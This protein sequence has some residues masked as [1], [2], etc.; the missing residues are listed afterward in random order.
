[1]E[2]LYTGLCC[3]LLCPSYVSLSVAHFFCTFLLYFFSQ[4][5][6]G[7]VHLVYF[8]YFF[9]IISSLLPFL[10]YQFINSYMNLFDMIL[11]CVAILALFLYSCVFFSSF[12]RICHFLTISSST[13]Y[14]KIFIVY[15]HIFFLI[16]KYYII[17]LVL[18]SCRE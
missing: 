12:I 16:V 4:M 1:M 17:Y 18:T 14:F 7:S 10:L 8:P 2:I 15:I 6:E 11:T 5:S 13:S 3:L 9:A